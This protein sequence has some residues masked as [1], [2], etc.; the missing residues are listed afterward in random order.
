MAAS[1]LLSLLQ[2]LLMPYALHDLHVSSTTLHIRTEKERI[3]ISTHLFL[4]D[5]ELALKK[6]SD[7]EL[8]LCTSKEAAIADSLLRAYIHEHLKV[9]VN[10]KARDL[11][12]L[13]KEASEDYQAV[14]VYLYI[15]D[16]Q[17]AEEVTISCD[18]LHEVY[19]D[20]RNIISIKKD[21]RKVK[22][23]VLDKEETTITL[24]L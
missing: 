15:E 23:E 10:G 12:V 21:R 8:K 7:V 6:V 19:D 1:I 4:D 18:Y 3:E 2:L 14:W 17:K 5:V 16:I 11:K 22:T 24:A 13:G 9:Q 20:Q